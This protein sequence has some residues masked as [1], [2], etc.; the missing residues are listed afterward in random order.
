[1]LPGGSARRET[2]EEEGGKPFTPSSTTG[3]LEQLSL[4]MQAQSFCVGVDA[5]LCL[6]ASTSVWGSGEQCAG[7]LLGLQGLLQQR[8]ECCECF[9]LHGA[10]TSA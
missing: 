4:N 3:W 8:L 7:L 1:M 9:C 10:L 6:V 2:S 5:Q